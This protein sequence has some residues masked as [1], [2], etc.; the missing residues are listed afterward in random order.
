MKCEDFKFSYS[1][2]PE[3]I[4][5]E[6]REHLANCRECQLF[7]KRQD[8]FEQQLAGVINCEV[9][10]GFRH[11]LRNQM[12]GG[13]PKFWRYPKASVALA[14]SL[15]MVVGLVMINA[16]QDDYQSLPI[17]QLVLEHFEHDGLSSMQASHQLT[18]L[19]LA[20]VSKEFG[21]KINLADYISFAEKCPIGDSYGLHM[22]Y[23]YKKQPVTVIYMPEISLDQTL[24]FEY[25]GL[26]GWAKPLKKGS[27]AV[28]GGSTIVLPEENFTDEVIEWL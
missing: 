18:P 17:D 24:P 8:T 2:A 14:A 10:E 12:A 11:S 27:I 21:I 4:E 9:P 5:D 23:Q 1:V 7:V 16:P 15:L 22:V 19:A 20:K 3:E 28:L 25:A 13:R 6:A 26:H